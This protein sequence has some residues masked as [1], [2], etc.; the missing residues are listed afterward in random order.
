MLFLSVKN[1]LDRTYGCFE[2]FGLDIMLD[3]DLK[4]YLIEINTNPAI[5]T[6]TTVQKDLIPKL[7]DDTIKLALELHPEGCEDGKAEVAEFM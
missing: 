1:R 6:D 3:E 5:F 2:L 4:P 7:V